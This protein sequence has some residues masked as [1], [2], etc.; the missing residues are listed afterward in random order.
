MAQNKCSTCLRKQILNRHGIYLVFREKGVRVYGTYET[1]KTYYVTPTNQKE[2]KLY[3][4]PTIKPQEILNN[5]IVNST[6]ENEVVLDCFMG[7]GSTGVAC[8]N[9][10]RHFIGIEIDEGYFEIAKK[11][12]EESSGEML[13]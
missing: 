1:K 4:H 9:T 6:K 11:R 8:V 2:K 10:G 3:G 13:C 5:L 12:I 7:S